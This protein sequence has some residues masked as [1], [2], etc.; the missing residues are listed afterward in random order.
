M[1][2]TLTFM[3]WSRHFETGL[4]LVDK[5]HHALVDMI[6]QAAPHLAVNDDVAKRAVGPLLDNL[7]RYALVHFRDEEQ[8]MV[9][10]RMAPAYL[11]Q[12]HKTHQAFVD[13]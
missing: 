11:Q 2:D 1:S 12:H 5:Q 3:T 4:A 9:Q 13:E 7:T 10:K 6:N 8:L